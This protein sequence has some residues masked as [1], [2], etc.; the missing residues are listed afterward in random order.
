MWYNGGMASIALLGLALFLSCSGKDA[1]DVPSW[2]TVEAGS[3][4]SCAISGDDALW[5]WGAN[6]SGQLG[7]GNLR[8]SPVPVKVAKG[9]VKGFRAVSM[10]YAHTCAIGDG[11][12]L[13]CWGDNSFGQ[14]GGTALLEKPV[15]ERLPLGRG[16]RAVAAGYAH[17]CAIRD[18]GDIV[19]WGFNGSGQ[20]GDGGIEDSSTPVAV[21]LGRGKSARAVTAGFSH[22]CALLEDGVVKCWGG[23]GFGQLGDGSTDNRTEPV[24]V[25]LGR[26]TRVQSI[27][28]G[29]S[30][31][32][33]VL[34]GGF[35]K[36]WGSNELRQLGNGEVGESFRPTRV[37]WMGV[38]FVKG[39]A[40]GNDYTC[41]VVKGDSLACWGGNGYGQLGNGSTFS[42][43]GVVGV[44]L[45]R[46]RGVRSVVAGEGHLCALLSDNSLVCWGNNSRGQLGD[47]RREKGSGLLSQAVYKS[48]VTGNAHSC[49][50]REDGVPECWG[51]NEFGQL[52]D[53]GRLDRHAPAPVHLPEG[54]VA[55]KVA[56]G[57]HHSCGLMDGHMLMCWGKNGFGQLGDGPGDRVEPVLLDFVKEGKIVDME[58]G[59]GHV[60]AIFGDGTRACRGEVSF[61]GKVNSNHICIVGEG[62]AVACRGHNGRGQLGVRTPHRGDD[63]GEMGDR[64]PIITIK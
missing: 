58:V 60:C 9:D 26:G 25:D 37:D 51:G 54:R 57:C 40:A 5:C 47:G 16:A 44:D 30:H 20:L 35:L 10:G 46:D 45:G 52:G 31:T 39:V 29:D 63:P 27:V 61:G 1:E 13:F 55:V 14:S 7:N 36:C 49:A 22:T 23:N 43:L 4:H 8:D 38:Q 2:R 48:V 56:A 53:G 17:T 62:G 34:K 15:P 3:F 50:L 41:A 64:L 19:C 6:G 32:C 18:G 21:D 42:P 59:C 33:A 24:K 11:H 28:A 12:G